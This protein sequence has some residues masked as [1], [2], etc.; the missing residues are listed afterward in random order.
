MAKDYFQDITPPSEP[1]PPPP[2]PARQIPITPV[3]DVEKTIRNIPVSPRPQ[4]PREIGD[5]RETGGPISAGTGKS[6]TRVWL[7]V[8]AGASVLVL[9][10]IALIALRPTSVSVTPRSHTVVFDETARFTAYPAATAAA[11]TLPYTLETVELEES[12]VVDAEGTENVQERASGTITVY[13]EYSASPVKLIKNTRFQT[14]DGL[15]FR[16]PAEVSVPGKSGT[17]PGRVSVTVIADA[18]GEQYNIGPIERFTLP[19]LKSSPD[20]YA[21]VY[22]KSSAAMSGGFAGER[23]R[24]AESTLDAARASMRNRLESKVRESAGAATDANSFAFPDLARVTYEAM[25]PTTE[26]GGGVRIYEKARVE[27][28]VFPAPA[29]AAVVAQSVSADAAEGSVQLRPGENLT[30]AAATTG[31]LSDGPLEFTLRGSATLVWNVDAPALAAALAG[32]EESAFETILGTFP[33]IEEAKARIEPFWKK[34]FPTDPADIQ[35]KI[36]EP[37]AAGNA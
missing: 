15:V 26:A 33:S 10:A 18:P 34:T 13:N 37:K 19:G 36:G 11:G 9:G 31:A 4:R 24:V 27:I 25:P 30:A 35:I 16:V 7:W 6:S 32:R 20:M 12:E 17:T 23:P 14:P 22:A 5:V 8:A 21:K 1:T 28:P 3:Q 29:F 2:P